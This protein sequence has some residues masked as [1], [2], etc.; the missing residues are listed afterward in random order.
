MAKARRILYLAAGLQSSGSTLVS[1]CFLQRPDMN[2]FL[3]ADHDLLRDIPQDIG[4]PL[5]WFKMTISCFRLSEMAAHYED[6]GWDVRPLLIVRDVRHVWNSLCRKPY[7]RNGTTAED[8][9][10][11]ARMRRSAAAR[12]DGPPGPQ[13]PNRSWSSCP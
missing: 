7:G 4:T 12:I 11:R 3:D 1:W 10:L 13:R 9:P 8:P 5:A 2:G 6:A